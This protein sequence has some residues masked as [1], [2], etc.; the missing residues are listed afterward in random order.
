MK[1]TGDKVKTIVAV[2]I[3]VLLVVGFY[4]AVSNRSSSEESSDDSQETVKTES[5]ESLLKKNL[6][7]DYPLTPTS[8]VSYYSDLLLAYY[9]SDCTDSM[10]EKLVEQS[11]LLYDDSLL[12]E[13]AQADQL[14]NLEE[15]VEKYKENQ[16]QIINYTVCSPEDVAYGELEGDDVALLTASYRI[17]TKKKLSDLQESYFL[18]KDE[19][20]RWKIMGWQYKSKQSVDS[21]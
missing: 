9:S 10:R 8:L 14:A 7:T 13:N 21:Q 18:R 6:E 20:G 4:I 19:D 12:E 17:R 5:G 16:Q 1:K 11:R 3:M 15:D 2:L